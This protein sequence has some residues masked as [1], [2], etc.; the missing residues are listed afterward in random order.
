MPVNLQ[1]AFEAPV[2]AHNGDGFREPSIVR[3]FGEHAL[4]RAAL[5]SRFGPARFAGTARVD[6][7]VHGEAEP[8][9]SLEE[10]ADWCTAQVLDQVPA[11]RG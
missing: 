10:L 7:D 3:L 9:G 1:A 5:P 2:A 8:A 4:T 11:G 6:A